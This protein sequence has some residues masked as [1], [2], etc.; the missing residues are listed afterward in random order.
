MCKLLLLDNDETMRMIYRDELEAWG[1]SV[2]DTGMTPNLLNRI[3]LETPDAIIMEE[4]LGACDGLDLLQTIRNRH[5]GLPIILCTAF[6]H[7]KHDPRVLAA[8]YVVVKGSKL[9]ELMRCTQMALDANQSLQEAA[10]ENRDKNDLP[11]E[12]RALGALDSYF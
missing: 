4:N 7:V 3:A 2:V 10:L 1:Y 5:P 9:E 11:G 12:K 6:P 8:D